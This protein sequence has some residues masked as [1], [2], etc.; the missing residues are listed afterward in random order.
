MADDGQQ[1][2][3]TFEAKFERYMRN[4]EKAQQ[5]TDRRFR[6]MEKRAQTAGKKMESTLGGS[7]KNINAMIGKIGVGALGVGSLVGF[8]RQ[9]GDVISELS[10]MGKIIDRVGLSAEA[11]QTLE[12]GFSLAGVSQS[13]FVT[14]MEQFVKRIGEASMETGRLYEI[15]QANGVAIRD[16]NGEIRSTED[17]LRTYANLIANARSEQEQMILATEAFGRG[18]ASFVNALKN[19]EKGLRDMEKATADAGGTISA[20]LIAKAEELDDAWAATWRRFGINAKSGIM[21]AVSALDTLDEK[22]AALG[23]SD[24]FKRFAD[25]IGAGGAVFVPGHGVFQ[26]GDELPEGYERDP[27]NP[28]EW[29]STTTSP[30]QTTPPTELAPITVLP[31]SGD[32][33]S[34]SKNE[35]AKKALDLA[36]AYD[37]L[38]EGGQRFIAEQTMEQ[39]AV[40]QTAT[41]A[42]KLK[43]EFDLLQGAQRAGIELSPQQRDEL[44]SLAQ[45]MAEVEAA[46]QRAAQSQEQLQ[47]A[48]DFLK[49]GIASFFSDII[50]GSATA[51]DALKRLVDT[52]LEAALQSALL[53]SGPLGFL[54]GDSGGII[55]SLF[56]GI[57]LAD[58]GLV[59]GPGTSTS[60]SI[61]A[62]LSN[63]E[64]VV[65]AAATRKHRQLLEA[66]NSGKG[67]ATGRLVGTDAAQSVQNFQ[68]SAPIKVEGSA[69]TPEQNEDLA[70]RMRRELEGTMRG[71]ICDEIRQ[72]MRPGGQFGRR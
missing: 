20:E 48:S 43:Y 38:I 63:G 14:G 39:Q 71:V 42:A 26:E 31:T 1:L 15:L 4:F 18:G 40:G 41:Q 59:R 50:S 49:G 67:F 44:S 10:E 13:Q 27:E 55:G 70:K 23:N 19:G 56:S 52:L 72:Q 64:Y 33:K 7:V 68:I 47:Q 5:Q 65:N 9:I 25:M 61:P 58:G 62:R 35:A 54:A 11:F 53:G 3:L 46:A 57:G 51:E 29:R 32:S 22:L 21:T 30:E 12:Y 60:D 2:L 17:L 45:S 36:E 28:S 66:V 16:Q 37:E 24:F 69:G 34:G 8:T 6:A